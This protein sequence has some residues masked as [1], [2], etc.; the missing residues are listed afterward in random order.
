MAHDPVFRSYLAARMSPRPQVQ[1]TGMESS[2]E[3]VIRS[4]QAGTRYVSPFVGVLTES[5]HEHPAGSLVVAR[6]G[7]NELKNFESCDIEAA[8]QERDD[9]Y[10]VREVGAGG[11][12]TLSLTIDLAGQCL[13]G[14]VNTGDGPEY[15]VAVYEDDDLYYVEEPGETTELPHL[16]PALRDAVDRLSM[17]FL[18]ALDVVLRPN[19]TRQFDTVPD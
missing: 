18:E 13:L 17:Q 16:A 6:V 7:L 12:L 8:P 9:G 19:V 15:R 4:S 3:S 5:W 2:L 10:T 14:R 1:E 11:L